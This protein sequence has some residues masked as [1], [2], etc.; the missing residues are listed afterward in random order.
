MSA[1]QKFLKY[2]KILKKKKKTKHKNKSKQ[3]TSVNL[4]FNNN[5]LQ[6]PIRF[7][8]KHIFMYLLILLMFVFIFIVLQFC[9]KP[10]DSYILINY[11]INIEYIVWVP[12]IGLA[13]RVFANES[14]YLMPPCSTLSIIRYGSRVN[15]SN[16]GK[17]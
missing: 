6:V 15:W 12:D 10:N 2:F 4:S 14:W 17:E 13:V 5:Y 1:R 16:P 8:H 11:W 9:L 3:F 7:F